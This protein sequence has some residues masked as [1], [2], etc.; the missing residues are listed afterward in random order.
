[1]QIEHTTI[2][3]T[4]MKPKQMRTARRAACANLIAA[5][6]ISLAPA[7]A[8]AQYPDRPIRIVVP[9]AA[10]GPGDMLT[11]ELA[12][13]LQTELGG[14]VI[15]DN[16]PGGGTAVG[17]NF[18][19]KSPADGYTALIMGP[20]THVILPAIHPKLPYHPGKDFD[21]IGM[22]AIVGSMISI[23]PA[24]PVKTLKELVDYT[25]ANPGKL[26]YSSA[27]VGTGPHLGGETFK[28]MTGA[29]LTHIPYKGAAP[30]TL[31]LLADEVQ[32]S[33]VNIPPQIPHV[34][35]G[36]IRPI[37]VS[38]TTRSSLLP[39]VPTAIEAGLPG[40]ISE[41]WYGVA[42]PAGTPAEVRAKLL[43]AM[44][45][46]GADPARKAR[47]AAGGAELKLMNAEE[48]TEYIKAEERRLKPVI[49]RLDLKV[50]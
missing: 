11:R 44:L 45:K 36:K 35:A 7:L 16:K 6:A 39:D 42:V 32:V 19:A 49:M 50:E 9:Y 25:K 14:S 13:G 15:T 26:S 2:K 12:N 4:L 48:T 17:A 47:M 46:A 8:G 43:R 24:L 37:A 22:W 27:G 40:Y 5:A 21:V 41:S 34:K 31:A 30:A 20:A 29:N 23:N 10:G 3:E 38:S 1:M 28:D 18:V 33:F